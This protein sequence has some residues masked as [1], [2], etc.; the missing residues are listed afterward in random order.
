MIHT[1]VPVGSG[2]TPCRDAGAQWTAS[3]VGWQA[4]SLAVTAAGVGPFPQLWWRGRIPARPRRLDEAPTMLAAVLGSR[5]Q[6][7]MS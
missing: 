2:R 1:K 3:G 4:L 6:R 7:L 5:L